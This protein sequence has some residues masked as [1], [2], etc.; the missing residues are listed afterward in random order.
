MTFINI[1][2]INK[3][4]VDCFKINISDI[5]IKIQIYIHNKSIF[6]I[7]NE[8]IK[9][10][11]IINSI[12]N[13]ETINIY[14]DKSIDNIIINSIIT[15]I[16]NLLYNYR[17]N[18][19]LNKIKLYN[20]DS[21]GTYLMNELSIYKEIVMHPNKN[22]NTYLKYIKSRIPKN[23]KIK[24][25]NINKTKK[26]PLSNA[27]NAGSLN[28]SYF[29]HI[30]PK[31]EYSKNKSIYLIGKAVIF[32]SGGLNLKTG[33]MS[34]MK[35]DMAGSAIIVSVLNLLAKNKYD[36]KYNIHIISAIVENMISNQAIRPGMVVKSMSNKTIEIR[37]TDAE[38]RLCLVDCIDYT[39]LYLIKNKNS[40]II[41]ISTLT[42]NATQITTNISSIVT[43]N[44]KGLY[45]L[46]QLIKIGDNIG[47]YVDYLKIREEYY[48]LLNSTVADISNISYE[49]YADCIKAAT[50]LSYFIQQDIPW[51]HIDLGGI[52]YID[53]KTTS[54]GIN[55][56]YEFIKQLV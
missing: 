52:V 47:E 35:I 18:S 42:G 20:I 2:I 40:I 32:D 55:L 27:V 33:D 56:L 15:K 12:N 54:Y 17:S 48:S 4:Q 44:A 10:K 3:L 53:S 5:L 7:N 34:D 14:F 39:N 16:N 25:Y 41:D 50:F 43:S 24:V 30:S 26:F 36:K 19:L 37:D 29:I 31:K 11:N 21:E 22:Q 23:Y 46:N 51:I 28:D 9:I 45:Y 13:I 1:Y 38:G 8:I 49:K 6:S